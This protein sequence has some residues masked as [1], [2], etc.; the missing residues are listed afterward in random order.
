MPDTR[1]LVGVFT[2]YPGQVAWFTFDVK[3]SLAF[4]ET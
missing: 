2:R 3:V 1:H 4:S